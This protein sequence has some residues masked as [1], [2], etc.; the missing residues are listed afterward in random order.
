MAV[1]I[2]GHIQ[3]FCGHTFPVG[4]RSQKAV[5]HFSV[6]VLAGIGQKSIDFFESRRQPGQIEGHAANQG[7]LRSRRRRAQPFPFQAI[8][9]KIINTIAGPGRLVDCGQFRLGGRDKRPVRF[10]FGALFD[11]FEDH[12]GF[13]RRD[14]QVGFRRRHPVV[15][16]IGTQAMK[17]LALSQTAGHKSELAAAFAEAHKSAALGVEPEIRLTGV[18]VRSVARETSIGK[19]GLYMEIEID[20]LRQFVLTVGYLSGHT[21]PTPGQIK[22]TQKQCNPEKRGHAGGRAFTILHVDNIG[23]AGVP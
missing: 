10:V 12:G 6:G 5:H 18:V 15:R 8:E 11:P 17:N 16:V 7:F 22:E 23:N 1:G 19:D 21:R 14:M 2:T 20:L 9:D 13:F 3:P 4:R